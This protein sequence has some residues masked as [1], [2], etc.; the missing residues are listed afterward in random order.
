MWNHILV[1]KRKNERRKL[2][3]I[4]IGI[5]NIGNTVTIRSYNA[6]L[7]SGLAALVCTL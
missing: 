6:T 2:K 1:R 7:S 4:N 5:L 3:I